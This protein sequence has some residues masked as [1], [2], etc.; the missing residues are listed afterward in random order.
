MDQYWLKTQIQILVIGGSPVTVAS[1]GKRDV[2]RAR[3]VDVI[4]GCAL[5]VVMVLLLVLNVRVDESSID[6][7]RDV[8]DTDDTVF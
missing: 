4:F 7:D 8:M 6:L 5:S 1:G 3:V 2:I